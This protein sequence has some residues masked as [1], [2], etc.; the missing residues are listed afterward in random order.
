MP[1]KPR[2]MRKRRKDNK[3]PKVGMPKL[4]IWY[5]LGRPVGKEDDK[6]VEETVQEEA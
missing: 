5:P 3:Q 2:S 6:L 1:R 4:I